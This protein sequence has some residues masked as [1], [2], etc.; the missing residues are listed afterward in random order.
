MPSAQR[1]PRP[2]YLWAILTMRCPRCRRG[3]LFKGYSPYNLKHVFDMNDKCPVCGQPTELEVGFWYGTGYV[4]Y[5][6]SVA[7]IVAWFVA[8]AVLI[9][10]SISDNRVFWCLGTCIAALVLLQPW[11]MRLSRTIYL[12][13]FV[14]YDDDYEHTKVVEKFD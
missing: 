14:H 6:L 12:N 13:F 3:K 2:S 1:R 5:A 8:W 4:S 11:L 10:I 9:G 7:F